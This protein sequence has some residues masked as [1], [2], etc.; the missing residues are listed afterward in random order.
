MKLQCSLKRVLFSITYT[1][2]DR[3]KCSLFTVEGC[4]PKTNRVN[5]SNSKVHNIIRKKWDRGKVFTIKGCSLIRGVHYER[6]H[7][8]SSQTSQ[9]S[10]V[11][12]IHHTINFLSWPCLGL[13]PNV[14]VNFSSLVKPVRFQLCTGIG[15]VIIAYFIVY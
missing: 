5:F 8:T 4:S 6:F 13:F 2:W 10:P 3:R 14:M 1:T 15:Y 11:S 7:C 12:L 9:L